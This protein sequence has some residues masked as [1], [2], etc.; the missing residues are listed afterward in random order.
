M[1]ISLTDLFFYILIISTIFY[2]FFSHKVVKPG[3]RWTTEIFSSSKKKENFELDEELIEKN[4]DNQD[5]EYDIYTAA[6]IP[7]SPITVPA[8]TASSVPEKAVDTATD[9]VMPSIPGLTSLDPP[10]QIENINYTHD[11][12]FPERTYQYLSD[13]EKSVGKMEKI[14]KSKQPYIK[15]KTVKLSTGLNPYEY[16]QWQQ[17][18]PNIF[19]KPL[20]GEK[21]PPGSTKGER[22]TNAMT[23]VK[24]K[25]PPKHIMSTEFNP[26]ATDHHPASHYLSHT[27]R[28]HRPKPHHHLPDHHHSPPPPPAP[29]SIT[30]GMASQNNI[31]SHTLD[32]KKKNI[33]TVNITDFRQGVQNGG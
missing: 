21:C 29:E 20:Y 30:E 17:V 9:T 27:R 6:G 26:Y 7:E 33:I 13:I 16:A 25:V 3:A 18:L 10:P 5:L 31:Y 8:E 23:T 12:P 22:L 11:H 24:C 1:K 32:P 19:G 28:D 4:N 2:V 14:Y 15:P